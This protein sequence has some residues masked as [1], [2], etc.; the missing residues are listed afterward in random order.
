MGIVAL[1]TSAKAIARLATSGPGQAII[2]T[3]S[4]PP[5]W[6]RFNRPHLTGLRKPLVFS[7]G[8]SK[9]FLL[10]HDGLGTPLDTNVIE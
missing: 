6:H 5:G 8:V 2:D 10:G 1:G 4:F 9:P 7:S 3:S